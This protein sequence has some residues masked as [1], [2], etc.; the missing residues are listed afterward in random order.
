ML[1]YKTLL[2]NSMRFTPTT[3]DYAECQNFI[4]EVAINGEASPLEVA[5]Q[6]FIE[7]GRE[8]VVFRTLK[9]GRKRLQLLFE[10]LHRKEDHSLGL[11]QHLLL[12]NE[13]GILNSF[14]ALHQSL[15]HESHTRLCLD[16]WAEYLWLLETGSI[17][18]VEAINLHTQMEQAIANSLITTTVIEHPVDNLEAFAIES[19]KLQWLIRT[20]RRVII[21][22]LHEAKQAMYE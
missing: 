2:L 7:C 10:N 8:G 4:D 21:Y 17:E 6:Y 19:A 9:Q 18:N 3:H 22:Q 20:T 5:H 15:K 13:T 14:T 1:D 12:L 16:Q 11:Q